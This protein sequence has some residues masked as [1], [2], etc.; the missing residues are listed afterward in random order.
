MSE[1]NF[2]NLKSY[3]G[4]VSEQ[5]FNKLVD[6]VQS[7][8]LGRGL[9]Y[10]LSR[11]ST[12]T[13]L[14]ITPATK[15]A[16]TSKRLPF[17]IVSV[18]V[19]EGENPKI[20]VYCNSLITN[21]DFSDVGIS[22][23]LGSNPPELGD[24]AA[25]DAAELNFGDKIWLEIHCEDQTSPSAAIKYGAVGGAEWDEYPDPFSMNTDDPFYPKQE[26]YNLLL[27]EV[28]DYEEDGRPAALA[29][30][31]GDGEDAYTL[32]ITQM[33]SQNVFLA[34][35]GHNGV[36]CLVPCDPVLNFGATT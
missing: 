22:G 32:Q 14:E 17:D 18:P 1:I 33:Y 25:I 36:V 34:Q 12:G 13:K 23:L 27:A 11:N 6:V 5:E 4:K 2:Y 8:T 29:I 35:W 10:K 15:G 24:T 26:Y 3:D 19:S 31:I 21:F 20:G 28:S 16:S 30:K 9:G 7:N